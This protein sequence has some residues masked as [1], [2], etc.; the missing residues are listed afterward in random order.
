M[1][2]ETANRNIVCEMA[3]CPEVNIARLNLTKIGLNPNLTCLLFD[4]R[5]GE[6]LNMGLFKWH[7]ATSGQE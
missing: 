5:N 6:S 4:K 7:P 1:V 3:G 2:H